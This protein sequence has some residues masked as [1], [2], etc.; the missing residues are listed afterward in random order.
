MK[1]IYTTKKYLGKI[2]I[3]TI[4]KDTVGP[5]SAWIRE[6]SVWRN[7]TTGKITSWKLED[8]DAEVGKRFKIIKL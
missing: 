5:D 6:Y 7:F 2:P 1:I 3:G 4:V 8:F